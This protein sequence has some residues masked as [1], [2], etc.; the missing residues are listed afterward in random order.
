MSFEFN[1][2][3]KADVD[4]LGMTAV[5][6]ICTGFCLQRIFSLDMNAVGADALLELAVL[7]GLC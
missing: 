2:A 4:A 5:A 1:P 6:V 3:K 7:V